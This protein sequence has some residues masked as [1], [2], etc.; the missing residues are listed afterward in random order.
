MQF[1]IGYRPPTERESLVDVIRDHREA[2]AECYF[3]MPGDPSGRGALGVSRGA[4][5]NEAVA[6]F[7]NE[8]RAITE[9][10]VRPVLLYNASC[11]GKEAVSTA[12]ANYL[13]RNLE[14][15]RDLLGVDCVTTTSTFVAETIRAH[16][17]GIELRASVNMRLYSAAALECL[18]PLFDSFYAAKELNRDLAALRR[19]SAWCAAHGKSLHLLANSG[20]LYH[21][22]WQ[23]EHDNRVAH[24]NE[25]AE[26]EN[27]PLTYPSPCWGH[28]AK[29][30]NRVALLQST[31]IRPEDVDAYAEIAPVIKLATRM[32]D[33]PRRVLEAYVNRCFD[34]NLLTLFEPSYLPV[35]GGVWL[36]NASFPA[37][38]HARVT[39]CGHDCG[40]CGYCAEVWRRV[41]RE[42]V[43]EDHS[44]VTA[45][46]SCHAKMKS[47]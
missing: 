9:L 39:T 10:G 33:D 18:A 30:E 36:D 1:S 35:L 44:V 7:W 31:W 5:D 22:P 37:D 25:I 29:P 19:L 4:L 16:F 42:A 38:W 26:N 32:H 8:L 11:Y 27:E 28:I 23:T 47:R 46:L 24:G 3:A 2:V 41:A 34:G 6:C 43:V 45:S 17:P 40:N 20:C 13:R 12:F 21:C 15:V 14:E